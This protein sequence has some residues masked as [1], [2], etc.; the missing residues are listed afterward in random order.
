[1]ENKYKGPVK[2]LKYEKGLNLFKYKNIHN[3]L[4]N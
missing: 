1:M 2:Y 4:L 3:I